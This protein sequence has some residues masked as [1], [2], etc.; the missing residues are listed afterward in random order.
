MMVPLCA[1]PSSASIMRATSRKL[2]PRLV[3][4]PAKNTFMAGQLSM[5]LEVG[6]HH[7]HII[8][9]LRSSVIVTFGGCYGITV[10]EAIKAAL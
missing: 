10:I 2:K 7:I 3:K 4:D 6:R 9:K 5:Y 1:S 8:G